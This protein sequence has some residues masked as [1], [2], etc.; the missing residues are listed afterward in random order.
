MRN[1]EQI[2]LFINILF[3]GIIIIAAIAIVYVYII[4]K[5]INKL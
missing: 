4:T 3:L 5:H 2:E 1:I